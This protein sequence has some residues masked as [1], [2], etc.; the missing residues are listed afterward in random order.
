M[1]IDIYLCSQTRKRLS[2]RVR[3]E[4]FV[5][6]S[7]GFKAAAHQYAEPSICFV[8]QISK[9]NLRANV[10]SRKNSHQDVHMFGTGSEQRSGRAE[11]LEPLEVTLKRLSSIVVKGSWTQSLPAVLQA[12]E[13]YQGLT[14]IRVLES[15]G[16]SGSPLES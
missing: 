4:G 12:Q 10:E 11:P 2:S 1:K 16:S 9:A 14:A 15:G 5:S 6:L 3:T 13:A 7:L 8:W